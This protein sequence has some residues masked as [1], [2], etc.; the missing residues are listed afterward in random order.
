MESVSKE[1][2]Q[3][4]LSKAGLF[5]DIEMPYIGASPKGSLSANVMEEK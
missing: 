5:V 3:C 4:E 2:E 1:H